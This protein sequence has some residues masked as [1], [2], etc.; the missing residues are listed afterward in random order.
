MD[1][2]TNRTQARMKVLNIALTQNTKI[3]RTYIYTTLL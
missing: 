1:F 2:D 3:H